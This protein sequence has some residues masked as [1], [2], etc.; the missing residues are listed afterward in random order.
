M[1]AVTPDQIAEIAEYLHLLV[2]RAAN[3]GLYGSLYSNDILTGDAEGRRRVLQEP[4]AASCHS[5]TGDLAH[6]GTKYQPMNLQN[7]WLWP[8]GGRGRGG[9][10]QVDRHAAVG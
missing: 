5:P 8:S 6:V 9:A 3:R 7:R 4:T 10:P 1:P 2:E